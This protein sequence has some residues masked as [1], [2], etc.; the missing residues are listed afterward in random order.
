MDETRW[1]QLLRALTDRASRRRLLGVVTGL[2]GVR[3]GE[4]AAKRGDSRNRVRAS[5][6]GGKVAICH[7]AGNGTYHRINVAEGAAQKHLDKHREDFRFIDCCADGECQDGETCAAGTC[8]PAVP[9]NHP[10]QTDPICQSNLCGCTTEPAPDGGICT[11]RAASCVAAGETC[12]SDFE[13]CNGT[14]VCLDDQCTCDCIA[15][16]ECASGQCG[17]SQG[18]CTCRPEE[19][20]AAGGTC[21]DD[22]DCCDG[23]CDCTGGDCACACVAIGG[24]CASD[25][26]CCSGLCGRGTCRDADCVSD[27]EPCQTNADCCTGPCR[28]GICLPAGCGGRCRG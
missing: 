16:Q 11:C 12:A 1:Q 2:T 15:P 14:C 28:D 13:C 7:R 24:N 25:G 4:A 8:T 17:C 5:R 23:P 18:V 20:M 6:K 26:A 27:T 10:G 21:A 22:S 3:V 19:C 9:C